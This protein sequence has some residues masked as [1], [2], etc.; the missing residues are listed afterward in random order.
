MIGSETAVFQ[1]R[2]LPAAT[3]PLAVVAEAST[4]V[5]PG[6]AVREGLPASAAA[7]AAAGA[8]AVVDVADKKSM[9]EMNDMNR[10]TILVTSR[11]LCV[12]AIA[13]IFSLSQVVFAQ[14][15]QPVAAPSHKTFATPQE[16]VDALIKA[17]S[18]YDVSTLL[19]IFG[20]Y[21]EDFVSTEDPVHDKSTGQAFAALARKKN[22]VTIDPARPNRATLIVG[23]DQWPFP[24]PL[25]KQKDGKW[26]FD[27]RAGRR[28]ILYRRIGA[29][30]LD[31][32][33]ICRGFVEAQ[34]QYSTQIHDDSGVNQYAQKL[35][36]SPGKQD[37]LYW[38]DSDGTPSGPI[39]KAVAKA[40]EEGYSTEKRSAFHGYYFKV[41]KGQGA[42]ARLGRLDYVIQGV[43]IGGF[44]LI[45]VP[46]EYRVTGVKTFMVNQDG[47]VYEKDLG[48]NSLQIAK[49]M[50]L[51]NP[52]KTWKRTDDEWPE[53]ISSDMMVAQ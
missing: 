53:A 3:A 35:I 9:V 33:Q 46:A 41:L 19:Q 30:E 22:V 29:N 51:Y 47:I 27:S 32:I 40:I 52:D 50:E 17:S 1:A 28:E 38:E 37:G 8:A 25:V 45:A 10:K 44:A 31:A 23:D 7:A 26:L 49:Q 2:L 15:K 4:A 42:A 11:I 6:L 16:A 48:P 36:S 5:R 21:G 14:A 12:A 43:M 34:L 18:D 24:V 13:C 39:S 20:P